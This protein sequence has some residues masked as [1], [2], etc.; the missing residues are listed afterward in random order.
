MHKQVG[1]PL[2][3][4]FNIVERKSL[5]VLHLFGDNKCINTSERLDLPVNVQHLRLQKAGTIT[6]YDPPAHNTAASFARDAGLV[7]LKLPRKRFSPSSA[8]PTLASG[9]EFLLPWLP[10]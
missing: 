1:A 7:H 4:H 3:N 9:Q 5:C 2:R 8:S 10:Q 6:C